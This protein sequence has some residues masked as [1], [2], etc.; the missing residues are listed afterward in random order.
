MRPDKDYIKMLLSETKELVSTFDFSDIDVTDS[1][2][3]Y[4]ATKKYP[5]LGLL[6]GIASHCFC[7]G[8]K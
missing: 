7:K 1:E 4:L 3:L 5:W 2:I 6:E 8:H